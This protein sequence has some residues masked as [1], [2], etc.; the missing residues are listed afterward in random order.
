MCSISNSHSLLTAFCFHCGNVEHEICCFDSYCQ[1]TNDISLQYFQCQD[2]SIRELRAFKIMHN[3]I[4]YR[5]N[6]TYQVQQVLNFRVTD[7]FVQ[8]HCKLDKLPGVLLVLLPHHTLYVPHMRSC[9]MDEDPQFWKILGFVRIF[10]FKWKM[11]Y[12]E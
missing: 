8:M 6:I 11:N 4:I 9:S 10:C 5:P 2:I 3:I 12:R 7:N 1:E